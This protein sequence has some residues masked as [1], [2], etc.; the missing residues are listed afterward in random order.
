[1]AAAASEIENVEAPAQEASKKRSRAKAPKVRT[2][3]LTCKIRRVKCDGGSSAAKSLN[4]YRQRYH[5]LKTP[6]HI[7]AISTVGNGVVELTSSQK[8]SQL[9]KDVFGLAQRAMGISNHD[10]R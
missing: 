6:C 1:M 7:C 8:E 4:L 2:G 10:R 9:A 5:N 3:C